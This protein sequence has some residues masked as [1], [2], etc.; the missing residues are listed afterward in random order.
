MMLLIFLI[1]LYL[2]VPLSVGADSDNPDSKR[3]LSVS[4]KIEPQLD[5]ET[6][7]ELPLG[8]KVQDSITK[9][10][11]Q[12]LEYYGSLHPGLGKVEF[13]NVGA[14][15]I[16]LDFFGMTALEVE[17]VRG[18]IVNQGKIDFR[19]VKPGGGSVGLDAHPEPGWCTMPFAVPSEE[20]RKNFPKRAREDVEAKI[21]KGLIVQ[22]QPALS[23][24]NIKSV[25]AQVHHPLQGN[26]LLLEFDEIGTK[27]WADFTGKSV[28]ERIAMVLDGEILLAPMIQERIPSGRTMISGSFAVEEIAAYA[29]LIGHPL[30]NPLTILDVSEIE[31]KQE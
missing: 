28:G 5:P 8:E 31:A 1:P 9:A 26:T 15:Q 22:R 29:A 10:L 4:I 16:R 13:A 20:V 3:D 11:K 7:K 21:G 27:I 14:D 6:G 17:K 25:K 12:R 24:G 2:A 30:Q 23:G 18:V 19:M